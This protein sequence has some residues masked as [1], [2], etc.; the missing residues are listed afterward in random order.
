MTIL[1]VDDSPTQRARWLYALAGTNTAVISEEQPVP[2]STNQRYV[3]R[4]VTAKN[5]EHALARL[6]TL[7]VNLMIT[8]VEMPGM[9]GWALA[10]AALRLSKTL[11]VLVFSSKVT[12]GQ[13]P[14][15]DLDM[16]RT[17]ILSKDDREQ[18][19]QTVLDLLH[20]V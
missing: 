13:A 10:A 16:S 5:G 11:K 12:T 18:A 17:Q 1:V 9:S 19:I 15:G 4:I 6:R 8:D 14:V 3:I 2:S 7:D 20:A